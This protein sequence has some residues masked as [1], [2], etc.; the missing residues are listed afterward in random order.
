MFDRSAWRKVYR[1]VGSEIAGERSIGWLGRKL[2]DK[3][4][5][6][7]RIRRLPD[8]PLAAGSGVGPQDR[9]EREDAKRPLQGR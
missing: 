2:L 6:R 5:A 1:L 7:R 8:R 4:G 3:I 9:P